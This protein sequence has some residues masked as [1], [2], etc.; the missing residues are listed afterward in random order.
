MHERPIGATVEWYTP[1]TLFAQLGLTFDLDPAGADNDNV[2]A[3]HKITDGRSGL[4]TPWT[5]RVWLN[6]PYGS[7]AVPFIERMIE[8]QDGLLLVA[9]RTETRWF[10]KAAVSAD[11]VCFLRDRLHFVRGDGFQ[12][13]SSHASVLMAWGDESCRAIWNADLGWTVGRARPIGLVVS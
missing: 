9:G 3:R 12:A 10:Q 6:P 5:G 11:V 13:R 7:Q 1:A 8:H 2:P 4:D